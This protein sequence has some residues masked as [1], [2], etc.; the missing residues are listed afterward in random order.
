[1]PPALDP[2]NLAALLFEQQSL[3]A[4]SRFSQR[5]NQ[6]DFLAQARIDRDLIPL[7]KPRPEAGEQYD[8][9]VDLDQCF[10]CKACVTACHSL[11]G[12]E[13]EESWRSAGVLHDGT[14]S[15]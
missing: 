1:M 12:L 6:G 13:E 5:H 9:E 11:N 4:A 15:S 14:A 2:L 7:A 8:F 3:T 10:G